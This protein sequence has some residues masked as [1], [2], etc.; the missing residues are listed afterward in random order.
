MKYA[1]I[2]NGIVINKAVA[3][4]PLGENWIESSSCKIGDLWD[5]E[6]FTSPPGPEPTIEE[7][8]AEANRRILSLCPQWKQD[9]MNRRATL[10]LER[11]RVNWSVE[12]LAEWNSYVEIGN[13]IDAI[14]QA[15]DI[16]EAMSPIPSDYQ[17]D[18]YWQ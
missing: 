15:S 12:E 14:R 10:L 1:I 9:N 16:L 3:E 8:K 7:I 13:Q 18:S 5:G 6:K 4:E 11:G 2:E 17:D